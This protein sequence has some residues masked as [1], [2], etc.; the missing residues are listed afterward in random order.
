MFKDELGQ[1]RI[2]SVIGPH[3]E[4]YEWM[5]Q[6]IE[7]GSFARFHGGGYGDPEIQAPAAPQDGLEADFNRLVIR[8]RSK[9]YRCL[10]IDPKASIL[11]EYDMG[12]FGRCDFVVREGRRWHC[13]ESKWGTA[14]HDVISQIDKYRT[15]LELD[16]CM[17]MHDYVEAVV[18]ARGFPPYVGAELSR[19]SVR[20]VTHDGTLD[21]L[22]CING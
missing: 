3:A 20:M 10:G 7:N 11:A 13:I 17:G 22:R 1:D 19:C 16:F 9:L 2:E 5:C 18:L 4:R 14:G 21:S 6:A 12:E 8:E 15:A